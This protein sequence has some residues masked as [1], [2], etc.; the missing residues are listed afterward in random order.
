MARQYWQ[1]SGD[2]SVAWDSRGNAYY[3]CQVFMRGPGGVTNNPDT[4]SAVYVF[5]STGDAGASWN[6]TGHPAVETFDTTGAILNDK[7]YMT[8]DNSP[9]SPFRD[10]IYVAWTLFAADGT[11]YIYEVHSDD[12]GQTFSSPVL[13]STTSSLCNPGSTATPAGNLQQ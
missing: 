6:F 1:A 4:S 2:P 7:P 11:A 10:R 3:S 12:Y 13:V 9:T 8:I 5:R